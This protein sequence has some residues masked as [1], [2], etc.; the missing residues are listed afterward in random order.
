MGL[1]N[2]GEAQRV[3]EEWITRGSV[4]KPSTQPKPPLPNPADEP[5]SLDHAWGKFISRG[6]GRS[7]S[8]STIFKLEQLRQQMSKFANRC[9]LRLLEEFNLDR[10]EEFQA[11]WREGPLTRS[12]KLG[13]LKGFFKA[14]V[15]RGWIANNPTKAMK[16][17]ELPSRP[18]LPFTQEDM[19]RILAAVDIYPDKSGKIGRVNAVRLRAFILILRY[20]G[21][22]IGDVT[23][24]SVDRLVGNKIFLYTQK[25]GQAVNCIVP[26]F[27]VEALENVTRLSNRYFFWTGNSTLHTGIGSWQ[28]TLRRLFT[29]AGIQKGHAHRLRDTFA[30]ELLLSG[31]PMEEVAVLLGHSNIGITQKHYSPWVQARQRQL[32][33]NLERV[34]KRDPI[35]LREEKSSSASNRSQSLPN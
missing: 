35:A 24:L 3:A 32:E 7:L 19:S 17:P 6:E 11:E 18:T 13:R 12:K 26:E 8:R 31:V 1:T 20:T 16:G 15:E 22:R 30:V 34:W 10:L 2:W 14:A 23:S 21:L 5:I 4:N 25:T 27:V 9:G 29:L 33:A 28:R